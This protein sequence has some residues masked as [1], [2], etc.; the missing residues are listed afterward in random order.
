[1]PKREGDGDFC[2]VHNDQPSAP[3]IQEC[4]RA[5]TRIATWRLQ[6]VL[7][8]RDC[9]SDKGKSQ[10]GQLE[11]S[12]YCFTIKR[13]KLKKVKILQIEPLE[14]SVRTYNLSII[15]NS[16]NYFVNGIL[17]NNESNLKH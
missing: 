6:K 14:E 12:D 4:K 16:D 7:Q 9:Y 10:T 13:N 2:V 17:V 1:L 3:S 5:E 15:E 8:Q 11:V